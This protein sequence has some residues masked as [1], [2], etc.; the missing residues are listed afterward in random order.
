MTAPNARQWPL[1]PA[2]R[3]AALALFFA[4]AALVVEGWLSLVLWLGAV[5]LVVLAAVKLAKNWTA[6]RS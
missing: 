2:L 5:V 1:A 6:R 3:Y 4:G